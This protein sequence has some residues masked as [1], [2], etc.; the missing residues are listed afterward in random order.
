MLDSTQHARR[1]ARGVSPFVPLILALPSLA[2]AQALPFFPPATPNAAI[3]RRQEQQQEAARERAMARLDVLTASPAEPAS[4]GP[5]LLPAETPCFPIKSVHWE[6]A[7]EFEWLQAEAGILPTQCVGG[8]GLQTIQDYFSARLVS[9]GYVTTRVLIPDQNLASGELRLRVV[10]GHI[11]RVT[12]EGAPGWWRTALPTGPGGLVNQRDL[13]QGMENMRR[14]QGQADAAILLVPGENPGDTELVVKPGS[15]KRWH[16]LVTG[17][18]AGLDS[19]GRYQMGGTLTVDSPLFLYDSLT[20]SGNTNANVGNGAAGTR[21]SAINY[22]IPF[23]YWNAF[24]NANQSRYHQTVAGFEGDIVYGGR[25]TQI[26]AGLGYVPLRTASGKT[27]LYGKV[28]RKTA[29]TTLDGIDIAVQHRDFVGYEVGASHRQYLGNKVLDFGAAWRASL[30]THSKAPGFVL[31]DPGWDGKSGIMLANAGLMVPFQV[32]GAR[33]RYQGNMRMQ[34]ARTRILPSEYFVIGNRYSVRGFD[35]QLTLAA[36]NGVT[37]RND[38]AW[39]LDN[40]GQ[41]A[42]IGFDA[43]HVSGPSAAFLAGQTLMG[44]VIGA[45]GRWAMG[46]YAALTY[47]VALGWPVKKPELFRTQQPNVAAQ[48]G[49]EF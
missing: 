18:N 32:A 1:K 41:E 40:T 3:E 37:W 23:G 15:G 39:Q 27:S 12:A 7:E 36:E 29:S 48:V 22:S 16:A 10:A 17:D 44:A 35:E 20:I 11:T 30:P 31:G 47:E 21:S 19:T 24:F 38:L 6:G 5:L 43:G 25:S 34:Y 49:L 26:E 4:A 8:K 46:G 14:L 13:D 2:V 45:R 28:F 42:F 9:Q 33:L